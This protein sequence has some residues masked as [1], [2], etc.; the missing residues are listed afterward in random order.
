MTLR[1]LDDARLRRWQIERAAQLERDEARRAAG[2]P[3][4]PIAAVYAIQHRSGRRY[5]G[6]TL[7]LRKRWQAHL[8]DLRCGTAVRRIQAAWDSDGHGSFEWLVLEAN[9]SFE[10]ERD[11]IAATPAAFL[12][13][14]LGETHGIHWRSRAE[15][16][17]CKWEV[18]QAA[19]KRASRRAAR[20][21]A[22][23]RIT[24]QLELE[25]WHAAT[26]VDR[27]RRQAA[28]RRGVETRRRRAALEGK[29][30]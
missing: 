3:D 22:Q 16:H 25:R 19:L 17:H 6:V 1:Q 21:Q 15:C 7:N 5:I 8:S 12:Y 29:A 30:W 27:E 20:A 28:A 23:R 2:D 10:A 14:D 26:Q 11:W 24:A 9:G 4:A 18:D 13:N